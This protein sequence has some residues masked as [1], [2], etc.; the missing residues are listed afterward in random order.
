MKF[1]VTDD[2]KKLGVKVVGVVIE[3]LDNKNIS[4][5]YIV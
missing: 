3:G 1:N 2:V 4:P 5:E